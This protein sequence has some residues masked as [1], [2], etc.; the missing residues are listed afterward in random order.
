MEKKVNFKNKMFRHI[1]MER[2]LQ[3]ENNKLG[4]ERKKKK[5]KVARSKKKT[6]R[7]RER[8]RERE[9]KR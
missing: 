9:N 1:W 6:E 8:E 5:E 4:K 3:K 7:E 2:K